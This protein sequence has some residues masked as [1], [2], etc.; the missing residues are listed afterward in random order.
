MIAEDTYYL[1]ALVDSREE[2]DE[3]NQ[4]RV[5]NLAELGVDETRADYG[6]DIEAV[7][8][9]MVEMENDDISGIALEDADALAE[10]ENEDE[11]AAALIDLSAIGFAGGNVDTAPATPMAEESLPIENVHTS[12]TSTLKDTLLRDNSN[13][14]P[15]APIVVED[16]LPI[17]NANTILT[18]ILKDALPSDNINT[19]PTAPIVVENALPVDDSNAASTAPILGK[20]LPS[21]R[22]N[23]APMVVTPGI[24]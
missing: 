7:D 10:A 21:D 5:D 19:V 20:T 9:A 13:T 11:V 8:V 2:L 23:T 22:I 17:D 6:I 18:P 14:A 15:A 4:F 24:P 12:L 3:L 1:L 16:T